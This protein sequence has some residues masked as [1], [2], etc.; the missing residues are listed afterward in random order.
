VAYG[1]V[2]FFHT[3]KGWGAISSPDI[4]AGHDAWVHYSEIQAEGFRALAP[5]DRV[6]FIL[7][8]AWQ[9]GYQFRARHVR[10]LN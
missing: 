2:K 5:G 9:D 10:K 8:Q 3:D 1:T 4:Q 7:E 6:E